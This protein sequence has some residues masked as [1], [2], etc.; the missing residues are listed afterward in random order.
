MLARPRTHVGPVSSTEVYYKPHTCTLTRN[1]ESIDPCVWVSQSSSIL[2]YPDGLEPLCAILRV[3]K[4][5][6]RLKPPL[7][8]QL[9]EPF[10]SWD[11]E[12]N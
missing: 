8:T 11:P 3:A 5:S 7:H 1:A 12:L 9:L 6:F 4:I 2:G 10:V